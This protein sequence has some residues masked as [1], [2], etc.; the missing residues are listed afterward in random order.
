M[1]KVLVVF[2]SRTGNTARLADA[3][4]EGARSVRFTEVDV[5]RLD[6]LA[7]ADVIAQVPGWKESRERLA[8]SHRTL[9]SY[10]ELANYDAIVLGSPTRYGA[11]SAELKNLID[12][13]GP[14]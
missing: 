6:D 1:P 7:P 2:Y 9:G 8:A 11:M 12:Q 13:T 5:R 3:I 14:L 4:A 10:E